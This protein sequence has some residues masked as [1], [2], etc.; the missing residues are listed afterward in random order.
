MAEEEEEAGRVTKPRPLSWGLMVYH[1]PLME[2][3]LAN[4]SCFSLHYLMSNGTA[5]SDSFILE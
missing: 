1:A 4:F 3:S 2:I 5:D